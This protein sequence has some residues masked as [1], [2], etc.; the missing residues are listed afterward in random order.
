MI[1]PSSTPLLPEVAITMTILLILAVIWSK[2]WYRAIRLLICTR[3][4]GKELCRIVIDLFA[5]LVASCNDW[6]CFQKVEAKLR[7]FWS[8]FR[9][10]CLPCLTLWSTIQPITTNLQT[11]MTILD[12]RQ[13]CLPH[14]PSAT[15]SNA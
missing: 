9:Q 13:L 15:D 14:R 12:F 2:S 11:M 8:N 1:Y 10:V 3:C 5:F 4:K 7:A 6:R